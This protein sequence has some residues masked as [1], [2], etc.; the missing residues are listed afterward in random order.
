MSKCMRR[1]TFSYQESKKQMV[2]A[3]STYRRQ[4]YNGVQKVYNS[5]GLGHCLD[6]G[7]KSSTFAFDT[8]HL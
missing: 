6:L 7:A 3:Y 1:T 4:T 8:D 5:F 2:L